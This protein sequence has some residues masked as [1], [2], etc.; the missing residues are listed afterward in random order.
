MNCAR[1][2]TSCCSTENRKMKCFTKSW[3]VGGWTCH[4]K[5]CKTSYSICSICFNV[6]RPLLSC[7]IV[8]MEEVEPGIKRCLYSF[9]LMDRYRHV[10]ESRWKRFLSTVPGNA[11]KYLSRWFIAMLTTS[12][13]KSKWSTTIVVCDWSNQEQLG[14]SD[15]N[16]SQKVFEINGS[17]SSILLTLIGPLANFL[18]PLFVYLWCCRLFRMCWVWQRCLIQVVYCPRQCFTFLVAWRGDRF[19]PFIIYIL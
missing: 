8:S 4:C 1:S 17:D 12:R 14:I 11:A 10:I 9:N 3:G 18:S 7:R 13:F 15:H 19:I 6:K 2:F 16:P 5:R